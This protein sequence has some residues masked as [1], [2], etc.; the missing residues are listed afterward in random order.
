MALFRIPMEGP[1]TLAWV[2]EGTATLRA[3]YA[4]IA[5]CSSSHIEILQSIP[6]RSEDWVEGPDAAWSRLYTRG[7]EVLESVLQWAAD[8][9]ERV[10][11]PSPHFEF[12]M[13][14]FWPHILIH[15][16]APC[17]TLRKA[18]SGDM[19]ALE[20]LVRLDK[21]VLCDERVR[22]QFLRKSGSS[23]AGQRDRLARA[24]ASRSPANGAGS[25][26][27]VKRFMAALICN[28]AHY[29]KRQQGVGELIGAS[30]V[31]RLFDALAADQLGLL[32]DPDF[33]EDPEVWRKSLARARKRIRPVTDHVMD[34]LHNAV[35][36]RTAGRDKK[37]WGDVP[38]T[39]APT[40]DRRP[41]DKN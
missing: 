1:A 35:I 7:R 18:R 11:P 33:P 2:E 39:G 8:A 15:R 30:T 19:Q 12:F 20:D 17:L 29:A 31:R 28:M 13:F 10:D 21:R 5:S 41:H 37:P 25:P 4:L 9:N 6:R 23:L 14:V 16:T 32:V 38:R 3:V 27:C 36:G 34:A 24:M 22:A 40:A 26:R